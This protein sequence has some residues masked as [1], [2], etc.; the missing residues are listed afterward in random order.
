MFV[1]GKMLQRFFV[2]L[3]IVFFLLLCG[4][5][6]FIIT[7][8]YNLRP[9]VQLLW[10]ARV[11]IPANTGSATTTDTVPPQVGGTDTTSGDT[12]GSTDASGTGVNTIA[13]PQS[14]VEALQSVGIDPALIAQITPAQELCFVRILGQ[15]RVT[16]IMAGAIPT[17]SEFLS[18]GECL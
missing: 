1:M 12:V 15:V 3:G 2:M 8:P 18:V 9:V 14:Q 5:A 16:E 17:T 7:D 13:L 10:N 6:F 11:T 4:A